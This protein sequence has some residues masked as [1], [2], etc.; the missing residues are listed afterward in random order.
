VPATELIEGVSADHVAAD[1]A[2]DAQYFIDLI[3]PLKI[4]FCSEHPNQP[5]AANS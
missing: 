1:K 4:S 5:H 3:S 2:Y